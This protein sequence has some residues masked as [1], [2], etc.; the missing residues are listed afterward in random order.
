VYSPEHAAVGAVVSTVGAAVLWATTGFGALA[1]AALFA[2]GVWLS[3]F[4]DLDHYLLARL[5]AGDWSHLRAALAAPGAA[6]TEQ[7]GTFESVEGIVPQRLLSHHLLGAALVVGLLAL[8]VPVAA[9]TAAI[10]YAHVVCD[11]LR[12]AGLA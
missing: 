2:W 8:S 6:L 9:F 11:L 7:E 12:D 10:L 1:L 5:H 3:V 4:V